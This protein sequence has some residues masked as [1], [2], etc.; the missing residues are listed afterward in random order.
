MEAFC[1]GLGPVSERG[2]L[3]KTVA[4]WHSEL[5]RPGLKIGESTLVSPKFVDALMKGGPGSGVCTARSFE[6]VAALGGRVEVSFGEGPSREIDPLERKL[7]PLGLDGSSVDLYVADAWACSGNHWLQLLWANLLGLG[8]ALWS[9]L[10]GTG[11]T[12]IFRLL[13]ALLRARS[14]DPFVLAGALT[15]REE[16]CR[17]HPSAVVEGCYLGKNVRIG[18]GSIVRGCW[19][20]EG[21]VVEEMGLL[22]VCVLGKG[23][24]LQRKGGAKYSLLEE[25]SALAGHMQLGVLGKGAMVKHGA[26]LMDLALGRSVRVMAGGKLVEAPFGLAGV[27]VGPGA[28]VGEGIK[29]GPGRVIPPGLTILPATDQVLV[30]VEVPEGCTRAR[31]VGQRLEPIA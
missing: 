4:S 31:V 19:L 20:S 1:E 9:S 17:I 11:P 5:A 12:M 29:I 22:D 8:P 18:A 27:C 6:A 30:K 24:R 25:D 21:A 7:P 3:G 10:V 2:L 26:A 28:I 16:G 13:S 23:A 14:L 15:W